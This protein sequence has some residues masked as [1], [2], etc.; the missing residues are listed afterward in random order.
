MKSTCSRCS[1]GGSEIGRERRV[2]RHRPRHTRH[3]PI[4]ARVAQTPY[5]PTEPPVQQHRGLS[6]FYAPNLELDR[7]TPGGDSGLI[8][9]RTPSSLRRFWVRAGRPR[10]LRRLPAT[11]FGSPHGWWMR[12]AYFGCGVCLFVEAYDVDAR[13]VAF[14]QLVL[15][16]VC[17]W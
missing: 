11:V 7:S 5:Q 15:F 1:S 16:V 2:R 3:T 17:H 9:A 8:V 14:V 4:H 6:Y 12:F 10:S 13:V